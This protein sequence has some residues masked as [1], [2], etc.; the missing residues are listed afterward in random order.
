MSSNDPFSTFLIKKHARASGVP[1]NEILGIGKQETGYLGLKPTAVS[2]AG[3]RGALQVMPGTAKRHVSDEEYGTA[4]GQIKAGV[5]EYKR[6]RE[7]YQDPRKAIR[8]Y[9]GGEGAINNPNSYDP[10]AK[11]STN[12]YEKN[13]MR[14]AGLENDDNNNPSSPDPFATYLEKKQSGSSQSTNQAQSLINELTA[15]NPQSPASR[16]PAPAKTAI[17]GS[18]ER[19]LSTAVP[20]V[21]LDRVSRA[22]TTPPV[23]VKPGTPYKITPAEEQLQ[24][25]FE[26]YKA[27]GNLPEAN[28]YANELKSKFGWSMGSVRTP[29]ADGSLFGTEWPYIKP[30]GSEGVENQV[31]QGAEAFRQQGV[32]NREANE[33]RA[34]IKA[35]QDAK[36]KSQGIVAN[37]VDAVKEAGEG[38]LLGATS[39]AGDRVAGA[40]R[41]LE[42]VTDAFRPPMTTPTEPTISGRDARLGEGI[43]E[44]G[45]KAAS[46]SREYLGDFGQSIPSQAGALVGELAPDLLLSAATGAP[47]AT[48]GTSSTFSS[49]GQGKPLAESILTGVVNA[50]GMEG[51]NVLAAELEQL[52][53][54]SF[55]RYAARA[56]AQGLQNLGTNA[57]MQGD[58]PDTPEK[59][60]REIL[61]AL[62]FGLFPANHPKAD[63][64]AKAA[65]DIASHP[66]THPAVAAEIQKV[67]VLHPAEE[68]RNNGQTV[69][70][71]PTD[72]VQSVGQQVDSAASP[73]PPLPASAEGALDVAR[74]DAL[75]E[76]APMVDS[77][78]QPI[79]EET[80]PVK[81]VM[82]ERI[83]AGEP[84]THHSQVENRNPDGTFAEGK[85]EVKERS[86]P[87]TLE[88]AGLEKGENTTYTPKTLDEGVAEAKRIVK[89]KGIDGAF[90]WAKNPDNEGIEWASVG[91]EAMAQ[92]RDAEAKLRSTDPAAADEIALRR[93]DFLDDFA[94]EATRKG[95]AIVGIKAI[96]EF[97]PDRA[98]FIAAKASRKNRGRGLSAQEEA[99]I[100]KQAEDLQVANDLLR[101]QNKLLEG[102]LATAKQ[103]IKPATKE[104]FQTALEAQSKAVAETLK[105]KMGKLDF[106]VVG[107]AS[108]RGALTIRE[109]NEPPLKGDAELLAQYAAGRLGKVDTLKDL[110]AELVS[111][112]GDAVSP[113]LSSITR[114]AYSIRQEARLGEMKEGSAET[115]RTI[116]SDIQKEISDLKKAEREPE[117]AYQAQQ[118]ELAKQVR[119]ASTAEARKQ[120]K[121]AKEQAI[122]EHQQ[123][124]KDARNR[125]TQARR[126]SFQ[127]SEAQKK[128][129]RE[130]LRE[131]RKAEKQAS[132]WDAPI[133][134]EAREARARLAN[135]DPKASETLSDLTSVAAEKLL[136]QNMGGSPRMASVFPSKFYSEMQAEFPSLV[137]KKN[138]GEIYKRATQR[139][140][141]S[142]EAARE[143]AKLKSADKESR[144]LWDE[145]GIDEEAQAI[146]VRRAEA[147][148]QQQ[149]AR[150]AMIQEFNHVSKSRFRRVAG[151]IFSLPRALQSSIDAPLGRQGLFYLVTHPIQT[152]KYSVPATF[153]GYSSLRRG[154]YESHVKELQSHP[155]Y[156]LAKG[157]GL[158]GS[159]F[160][161]GSEEQFRSNWGDKIPHARLSEQAFNL[162]MDAQRLAVFSKYADVGRAEGYT[163]ES[164]PE[165]FQQAAEFVNAATGRAKMPELME[166]A[167]PL[168]N[169]IFYSPRLQVSRIKLMNNL[170]NPQKYI[171][172]DPAMRKIAAKEALK[173]VIGF[174]LIYGTFAA[175]SKKD[176]RVKMTADP[177][178]SDFGKVVV[179]NTHY[180]LSGGE[181]GLIRF[182][183]RLAQA[184]AKGATGEKVDYG[185]DAVT[186]LG[187]YFRTKLA[188]VPGAGLNV[189][190][191]KDIVGKPANLKFGY[192]TK[193]ERINTL[194]QNQVLKLLLP[195]LTGDLTDAVIDDG[196]MGVVK[197]APALGGIGSNTFEKKTKAK[198]H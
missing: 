69:E 96:E 8:G 93:M 4:E 145:L 171:S 138:R 150:Q 130:G 168:L 54:G 106:G 15:A 84:I 153:K 3:A 119:Q 38:A 13:V 70:V 135:A 94:A 76:V 90:E 11:I 91:Y 1:E 165:F 183:Y 53:K 105:A 164:N 189:I 169:T 161:G 142:T 23:A 65:V 89:E 33:R 188:P 18:G 41:L 104:N 114:R 50:R 58:V 160:E 136:P 154:T 55:G 73:L 111:E 117:K 192:K 14:N 88:S 43:K 143:V 141:D 42:T 179:G 157:S 49:Y 51:G 118:R 198:K 31:S 40:G 116:L 123:L 182:F 176:E 64:A 80:K 87:K 9:H 190:A 184:S 140:K 72:R 37:T 36:R 185:K 46:S 85:P 52:A 158:S 75:I 163:F 78:P 122:A 156:E 16:I 12:D 108:E 86:L 79:V 5:L 133:R 56:T 17:K 97:A 187:Q 180:D 121:A 128:A 155:D 124:T 167:K 194:Q 63:V 25:Y 26:E 110:K 27:A 34:R 99:R 181:A 126:E 6:L 127:A 22:K 174:G 83:A 166:K 67:V 62:G 100:T 195:M 19:H 146:M 20:A 103:R 175:L 125:L 30:P 7:K 129:Y 113:H 134:N 28:K 44:A 177:E 48:F 151:E 24:R 137:T 66:E 173:A 148:R 112:F 39:W 159:A 98:A 45:E 144:K 132:L 21:S 170:L 102:K 131:N 77:P 139:I 191:G 59:A 172:Y 71:L 29:A 2:P 47:A 162:G 10:Y 60:A 186:I 92:S 101:F 32:S 57:A 196:W 120:A 115:R 74:P 95:Q 61:F 197:T 82:E 68:I 193:Q 35:Q 147:Q 149:Q 107:K 81:A 109:G 178:D 152:M